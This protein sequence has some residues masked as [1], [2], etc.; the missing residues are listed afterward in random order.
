MEDSAGE[1]AIRLC[2][3]CSDHLRKLA[4]K[5]RVAEAKN[6]QGDLMDCESDCD[7]RIAEHG[8]VETVVANQHPPSKSP[9]AT[10]MF[11]G[12]CDEWEA[13][14]EAPVH[15]ESRARA[16]TVAVLS[17]NMMLWALSRL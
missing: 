10:V 6:G 2:Q 7:D 3:S 8:E 5:R 17:R 1:E 11:P 13:S 9:S 15:S 16:A 14:L 4:K 12:L